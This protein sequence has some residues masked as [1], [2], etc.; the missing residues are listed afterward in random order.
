VALVVQL[1]ISRGGVPKRAI[2][3]GELTPLGISGDACAHSEIH[4]G[5]RQAVLLITS[6]GID[7]LVGQGFPIFYGALGENITT[8]G[9][10]RRGLRTGQRYRI[11]NAVVELTKPRGPCDLLNVYG[12]GMQKAVYDAQ[13]KAGDHTSSRWGLSGFYASVLQPGLIRP[14]DPIQ[15]LEEL[16]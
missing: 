14:G 7:E 6:E 2:A 11:G 12:P 8:G 1:N 16:A 3:E 13:V 9:L 5:P 10:D 15:L 4:G